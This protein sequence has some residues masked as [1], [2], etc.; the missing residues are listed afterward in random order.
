M[1]TNLSWNEWLNATSIPPLIKIF[2]CQLWGNPQ[3]K[4]STKRK[5]NHKRNKKKKTK[6]TYKM[7]IRHF[8]IY[9]HNLSSKNLL[10]NLHL[11]TRENWKPSLTIFR[12]KL[13]TH[14][15]FTQLQFLHG[16]LAN[17]VL[18]HNY[19]SSKYTQKTRYGVVK[20]ARSNSIFKI[21]IY[22]FFSFFLTTWC[23]I[24]MNIHL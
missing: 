12:T 2:A 1:I 19:S 13:Q 21:T 11:F 20:K 23:A 7:M 18:T 14:L 15:T 22:L 8:M 4:I 3:K 6:I 5:H 16:K 9:I 17:Y 10:L 24:C